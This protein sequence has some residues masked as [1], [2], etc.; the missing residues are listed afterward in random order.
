ML[1]SGT[2]P[3]LEST[4][5]SPKI[6]G[7][8]STR[9]GRDSHDRNKCS[10]WAKETKFYP[11]HVSTERQTSSGVDSVRPLEEGPLFESDGENSA[12]RKQCGIRSR[13][14]TRRRR[15]SRS[16]GSNSSSNNRNRPQNVKRLSLSAEDT[17][18]VIGRRLVR[19]IRAALE[20]S[21]NDSPRRKRER[22]P[23]D[24]DTSSRTEQ[25]TPRPEYDP[26]QAGDSR[27]GALESGIEF[28]K[29]AVSMDGAGHSAGEAGGLTSAV[30]SL[31]DRLFHDHRTASLGNDNENEVR[32]E[33][34]EHAR[35]APIRERRWHR[36]E[37]CEANCCG[38]GVL[39]AAGCRDLTKAEMLI[40]RQLLLAIRATVRQGTRCSLNGGAPQSPGKYTNQET[41]AR[42]AEHLH[43]ANGQEA[44]EDNDVAT[45]R[46]GVGDED[47][48]EQK[49]RTNVAK[50]AVACHEA[51]A[52]AMQGRTG[53]GGSTAPPDFL[54][55]DV[56]EEHNQPVQP[57]Y[58]D[59]R[60]GE[61]PGPV[62]RPF[63]K[64][65]IAEQVD[66]VSARLDRIFV[67]PLT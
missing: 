27:E 60:S 6:V 31:P 23:A 59:A 34:N 62:A 61:S 36:A 32:R 14:T 21:G 50:H 67:L 4:G 30:G 40:A 25:T 26:S 49:E 28:G 44:I 51:G 3:H 37:K 65:T 56:K 10:S 24:T 53:A 33:P 13:R 35:A 8:R 43:V 38:C 29:L 45:L 16:G 46:E 41:A 39:L 64:K 48:E 2:P 63:P 22:G 15:C 5:K 7:V 18:R 55:D 42:D 58:T 19:F 47:S 11:I 20:I 1:L 66:E 17:E 54:E 57:A 9:R 12:K 52:G